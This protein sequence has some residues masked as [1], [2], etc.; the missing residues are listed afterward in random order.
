LNEVIERDNAPRS[1]HDLRK[2]GVI[3]LSAVV[4]VASI[5]WL[6]FLAVLFAVPLFVVYFTADRRTFVLSVVATVCFDLAMTC[7]ELLVSGKNLAGQFFAVSLLQSVFLFLPMLCLLIPFRLRMRYRLLLAGASS[8]FLWLFFVVGT[9][10]GSNVLSLMRDISDET[11]KVLY[12]MVPEGFERTEFMAR[13]DSK[14]L[15]DLTL[16]VLSCSFIGICFALYS[17]AC[18]VA[19]GIAALVKRSKKIAF[20]PSLFYN[21]EALFIPLVSAM[22]CVIV[23][24]FMDTG[25][26]D[27]VAWNV[28]FISGLFF[29]LQGYAVLVFF[30]ELLRARMRRSF[31]YFMMAALFLFAIEGWPVLLCVFFIVGVVELFVPLR[32]RFIN[33]DIVD[34]TPGN[35]NDHQ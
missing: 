27:A 2:V 25:I 20:H 16:K 31:Y 15:Y 14:K 6:P 10:A 7:V 11:A 8:A 26:L 32:A 1:S 35:G 4:S 34:P 24:R 33:K 28:L 29:I 18:S 22:V 21:D 13:F 9:S 23:G 30:I 5:R 12:G 19:S 3:V 17:F